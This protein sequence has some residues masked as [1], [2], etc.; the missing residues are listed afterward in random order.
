MLGLLFAGMVPTSQA[1]QTDISNTPMASVRS[2]LVKPNIMLL[3]DTSGSMGWTHMPDEL[4]SSIGVG[5]VG[6]KSP[7][8]NALYY[9][10]KTTYRIPKKPDGSLFATPAFAAAPYAGYVSY[11]A[12]PDTTDQSTVNLSSAFQAFAGKTL[13]NTAAP[14]DTPQAAYYY[15]HSSGVALGYAN[16]ACADADTGADRTATGGGNW[17]RK[18]VTSTSG[19][20]STTGFGRP[21]GPRQR[22][23]HEAGIGGEGQVELLAQNRQ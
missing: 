7:Q 18:L 19:L 15:V 21:S 10:P 23:T 13:R 3:M 5:S 4:E 20:A 17:T 1:A 6:Y 9:N 12:A 14:G 2:A 11:F 16:A 22:V 8:C